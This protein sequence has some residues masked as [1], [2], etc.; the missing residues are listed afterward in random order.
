MADTEQGGN[1]GEAKD[2]ATRQDLERIRRLEQ[3]PE[4]RE[5]APEHIRA[6][7]VDQSPVQ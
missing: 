1:D 7:P 2:D 4:Q 3:R 6:E 5:E